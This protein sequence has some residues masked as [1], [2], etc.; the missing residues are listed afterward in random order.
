M[1]HNTF[2]IHEYDAEKCREILSQL[3]G[4]FAVRLRFD[5]GQLVEVHVLASTER[6][7]KQ[8]ARDIQSTLFAVYGIEIDHRIISIA[9]LPQ[10]PFAAPVPAAE[11]E[12]AEPVVQ[13]VHDTRLLFSGINVHQS[14]GC[15][16]INVQLTCDGQTYEGCGHCRDTIAQRNRIVAQATTEAVNTFLGQEYFNSL[17]VK[18]V[19]IWGITVAVTLI[20]YQETLRSEPIM[21]VGAAAM[22]DNALDGIVRSTLDALNRSIAKLHPA[23]I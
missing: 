21:L 1:E 23:G 10:D 15:F 20:E 18:L 22:T 5:N 14:C 9:Q 4:M 7:P 3:P 13:E 17:D 19:P 6:N 11:E 12:A 8:I 2:G 16:D